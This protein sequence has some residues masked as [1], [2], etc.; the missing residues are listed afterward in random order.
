MCRRTWDWSKRL[1]LMMTFLGE[2]VRSL[3]PI[4]ETVDGRRAVALVANK[5]DIFALTYRRRTACVVDE[6]AP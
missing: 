6:G 5:R 4:S 2:L 1:M 3:L